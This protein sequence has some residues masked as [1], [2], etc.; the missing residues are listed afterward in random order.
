MP[1]QP[2]LARVEKAARRLEKATAEADAARDEWLA[3]MRA[4]RREG[5]SLRAIAAAA[6]ISRQRVA[7]LLES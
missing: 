5:A 6:G 4:A 3:A 2:A 7:Q 1:R